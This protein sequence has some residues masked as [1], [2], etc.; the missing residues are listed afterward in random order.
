[1]SWA[2]MQIA[3]SMSQNYIWG[4]YYSIVPSLI[5]SHNTLITD[6]TER[7]DSNIASILSQQ[8]LLTQRRDKA[9]P[10]SEA[11]IGICRLYP[12]RL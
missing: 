4:E 7:D 1:M 12:E 9:F 6:K 10:S 5:V 2:S 8:P 3:I 11:D